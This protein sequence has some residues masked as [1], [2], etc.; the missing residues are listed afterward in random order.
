MRPTPKHIAEREPLI[1]LDSRG[2]HLRVHAAWHRGLTRD[3]LR[4]LL[5]DAHIDDACFLVESA[6]WWPDPV[7]IEYQPCGRRRWLVNGRPVTK[8]DAAWSFRKVGFKYKEIA[9]LMRI[10]ELCYQ[11]GQRRPLPPSDSMSEAEFWR[12]LADGL[13]QAVEPRVGPQAP[14]VVFCSALP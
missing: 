12:A 10:Y 1:I 6:H 13:A 5:F 9:H 2:Y 7:E 8:E 4:R 14:Q 3:E 11:I